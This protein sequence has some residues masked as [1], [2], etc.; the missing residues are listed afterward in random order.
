MIQNND[1]TPMNYH[2]NSNNLMTI[3][4]QIHVINVMITSRFIIILK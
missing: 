1:V 3:Q 4:N 2:T